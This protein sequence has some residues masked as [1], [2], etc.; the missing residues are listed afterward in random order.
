MYK[1]YSD[2]YRFVQVTLFSVTTISFFF[3]NTGCRV[4]PDYKTPELKTPDKFETN[5]SNIQSDV[6]GDLSTWWTN[7]NDPLL[8]S[9]IDEVLQDNLDI[10]IAA[11]RID[12]AQAFRGI[13]SGTDKPQVNVQG[14]GMREKY[15]LNSLFG[16]FLSNQYENDFIGAL[17]ARW[18]LDLFGKNARSLEAADATVEATIEN[19][20]AVMVLMSA[21]VAKEYIH[22]RQLQN[23]ISV[24]KD[25]IQIQEDTIQIVQ[26]RFDVGLVNELVLQQAKAQLEATKS[27]LPSLD[28]AMRRSIHRIGILTGKEPR[29]L[30]N[31][32]IADA[33]I[34]ATQP[35]I[36]IGLPSEL[37]LRRPDVRRAERNLA[38]ATANI[39]VATADL[40]PRFSL[41]GALGL[42]STQFSR[43]AES[44]SQ[45]WTLGT[46]ISW[47]IIDFGTIRSNIKLQNAKQKEAMDIYV[48][49]TLGA[50]ED[51]ENALVTYG[52]EQERLGFL[53]AETFAS[54]RTF[55]LAKDRYRQGLVDFLN[56]LDAQRQLYRAQDA[57]T[58]SK[59]QLAID[60]V[61]LYESLGGGWDM[62]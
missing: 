11:D 14:S 40:F 26:Q 28:T 54:Q 61:I 12:Q 55:D 62:N 8:N 49:S 37:L 1:K 45:Y 31:K 58:V 32:L 10:K 59:G 50:F 18:E 36:P 9:I 13:I 34:P 4:G 43:F 30:E 21:Q 38:A 57:L 41:T 3:I 47:P 19:K 46:G 7:M 29:A 53:E 27:I 44:D 56:V 60:L 52:N 5:L 15:S 33:N 2:F 23:Q 39:G 25:N 16:P 42:E 48:K 51:V 22:L 24:A 6:S 35:V 20:S 17:G